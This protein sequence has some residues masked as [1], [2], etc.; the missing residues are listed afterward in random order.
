MSGGATLKG[1]DYLPKHNVWAEYVPATRKGKKDISV[2]T[3]AGTGMEFALSSTKEGVIK[4]LRETIAVFERVIVDIENGKIDDEWPV[5]QGGQ[6][7]HETEL[8]M[9]ER[10]ENGN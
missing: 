1:E 2:N 4:Q 6:W 7:W 10:K 3:N 9:I 5:Y 8:W